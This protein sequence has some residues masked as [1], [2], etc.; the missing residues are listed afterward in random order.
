MTTMPTTLFNSSWLRD[1][2]GNWRE[3]TDDFI[4]RC[5]ELIKFKATFEES[6]FFGLKISVAIAIFSMLA[7]IFANKKLGKSLAEE[8]ELL[9]GKNYV[10]AKTLRKA[11]KEKGDFS[12]AK[13]PY[14]KNS[15]GRHTI[16][17]GTTGAGK[18]NVMIELIDQV[19][20]KNERAIIVDTVG[21]SST[22]IS[23]KNAATF[24]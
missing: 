14:P 13:I 16:V 23:I 1:D 20:A 8:K 6:L 19:R 21:T 17:T 5:P 3:F 12:L 9:S 4:A 15:E 22:N 24:C 10:D 7:T 18:S 11:I 2:S